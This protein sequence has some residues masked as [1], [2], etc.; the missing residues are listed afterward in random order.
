VSE[1]ID[2][3]FEG[4]PVVFLRERGL[5]LSLSLSSG[6]EY[7]ESPRNEFFW[8]FTME[9]ELTQSGAH[10]FPVVFQTL[11]NFLTQVHIMDSML[12]ETL[13]HSLL[14]LRLKSVTFRIL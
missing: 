2:R 5:V 9:L 7:E 8:L 10:N 1:I 6:S 4:S 13:A 11:Q 3:E 12:K 14:Y